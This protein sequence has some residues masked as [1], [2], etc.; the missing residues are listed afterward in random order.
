MI[1][2]EEKYLVEIRQILN[3]QVPDC[4]VRVFGSRIEGKA[5]KFSDLDLVLI[6]SGKLNWRRIELLKDVLAASNL[7]MTVDVL[8]YNAISKEFRAVV[9]KRYEVIQEK[10]GGKESDKDLSSEDLSKED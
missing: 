1:D 7:P 10:P 9:D 4:E 2:I 5:G 6:G 8:D 3:E